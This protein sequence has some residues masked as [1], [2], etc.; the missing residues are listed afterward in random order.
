MNNNGNNWNNI[1]DEFCYGI[2]LSLTSQ[3]QSQLQLDIF[4]YC[5]NHIQSLVVRY[6]IISN[7]LA[8]DIQFIEV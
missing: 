4:K 5:H 3:S 2:S 8:S 6:L 1:Y 7:E